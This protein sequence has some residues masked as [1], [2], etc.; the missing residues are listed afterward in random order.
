MK[1]I[2]PNLKNSVLKYLEDG[3][4]CR[5]IECILPVSRATVNRIQKQHFSGAKK[6]KGGRPQKLTPRQ[7]TFCVHQLT[8]GGKENAS[9]VQEVLRENLDVLVSKPTVRRALNEAG[10]GSFVKPK[11]PHLSAKNIKERLKFAKR[12]LDWTIADWKRVIWSDE[13]KINRFGTDGRVWAWK[14]ASEPLQSKHVLQTV[15]HIG[16]NIKV[17]S[18]IT[19]DGVGFIVHIEQNLTKEIYK[20]I[21]EEDLLNSMADYKMKQED[22]IFQQDNDPK[23]T[24]KMVREWLSKQKFAVMDWPAQSPDLNPIENMWSMLKKRLFNNYQAPPKGMTEL[25]Q[26]VSETWYKI[27]KEE[28]QK[29]IQSMPKRCNDIIKANG[30]WIKY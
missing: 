22:V 5:E 11:K 30:R 19:Y 14:R 8:V 7:K 16:G 21:L 13:T 2:S 18:C 29:V 28:C 9:Q 24:S 26:R 27:K 10:L 6:M 4:S 15:K 17:W 12:H 20:S 25:W 23:H 1:P 3:L